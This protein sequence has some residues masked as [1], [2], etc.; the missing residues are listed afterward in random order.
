MLSDDKNRSVLVIILSLPHVVVVVVRRRPG[1]ATTRHR[2]EQGGVDNDDDATG[3]IRDKRAQTI[4]LL[5]SI[6][7]HPGR[8]RR[9][10]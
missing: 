8:R 4:N 7:G 1:E 2:I 6:E 5:L 3:W 10:L 9:R